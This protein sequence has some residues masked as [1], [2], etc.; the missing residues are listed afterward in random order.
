MYRFA[1]AAARAAVR[2][3]VAAAESVNA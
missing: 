2:A 3:E 1:P